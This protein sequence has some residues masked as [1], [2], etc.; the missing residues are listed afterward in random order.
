MANIT[1]KKEDAVD[2]LRGFIPIRSTTGFEEAF[3]NHVAALLS[4]LGYTVQQQT[5]VSACNDHP[6]RQNVLAYHGTPQDVKILFNSHLDTV[7][8]HICLSEDDETF[9]GRGACDAK[10]SIAAQITAAQIFLQQH[11]EI[12]KSS[13]GFLYV[14]G[15][16]VNH[17]GM[18]KASELGLAPEYV[19]VGEPTENRQA[20]GH[21]GMIRFHVKASGKAAHSGYPHLGISANERLITALNAILAIVFCIL[22]SRNSHCVEITRRHKTWSNDVECR[23]IRRWCRCQ[24]RI[25]I[26]HGCVFSSGIYQL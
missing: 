19:I 8:P 20:L 18:I 22:L 7:P 17:I 21:K 26:C 3:S 23:S 14:V 10:A 15:E 2:L 9:Y 1:T 24:C 13:I 12:P 6:I 4:S 11:P 25:G 16:E 5:V